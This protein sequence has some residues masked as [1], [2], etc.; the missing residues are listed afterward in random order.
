MTRQP[1][2]PAPGDR[3]FGPGGLFDDLHHASRRRHLDQAVAERAHDGLDADR[4]TLVERS[5]ALAVRAFERRRCRRRLWQMAQTLALVQD[6][7]DDR[8]ERGERRVGQR[9]D[10]SGD[11]ARSSLSSAVATPM[12]IRTSRLSPAMARPQPDDP[13]DR[14]AADRPCSCAGRR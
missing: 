6:R 10:P 11:G 4:R 5:G 9:R 14:A 7:D 13:Q 8:L 3:D 1:G 12:P 2:D